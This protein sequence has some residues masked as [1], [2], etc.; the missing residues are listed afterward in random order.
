[1]GSCGSPADSFPITYEPTRPRPRDMTCRRVF[2]N[3][4]RSRKVA[5]AR[6]AIDTTTDSTTKTMPDTLFIFLVYVIA[7]THP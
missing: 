7:I 3:A 1:M 6:N 2:S 5:M 4:V